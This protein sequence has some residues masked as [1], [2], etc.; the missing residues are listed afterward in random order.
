MG[1]LF[2]F[3]RKVEKMC[4]GRVVRSQDSSTNMYLRVAFEKNEKDVAPVAPEWSPTS[5]VGGR[6]HETFLGAIYSR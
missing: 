2:F 1:H 5:P 4:N 6:P 3:F